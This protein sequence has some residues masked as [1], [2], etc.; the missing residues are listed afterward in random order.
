MVRVKSTPKRK[1]DCGRKRDIREYQKP[2]DHPPISIRRLACEILQDIWPGARF[3]E[4]AVLALQHATESYMVK[5]F[6]D[7]NMCAMHAK[8]KTITVKDMMLARRING[9]K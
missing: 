7:A 1:Q 6:K 5:L 2:A 8:R 9:K 3:Q 4:S